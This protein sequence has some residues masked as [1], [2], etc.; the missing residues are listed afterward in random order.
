MI[1]IAQRKADK[2][3]EPAVMPARARE[4]T[5]QGFVGRPASKSV[6]EPRG[7]AENGHGEDPGRPR[8]WQSAAMS[9]QALPVRWSPA[10][11]DGMP[12]NDQNDPWSDGKRGI[13]RGV[14]WTAII[15]L[16]AWYLWR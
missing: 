15:L 6:D 3:A 13:V 2:P 10:R 5:A 7:A 4:P 1:C 9:G 14:I 12:D 16:V 8:Q 11:L